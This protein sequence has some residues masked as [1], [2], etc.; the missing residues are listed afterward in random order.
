MQVL[1]AGFTVSV[2]YSGKLKDIANSFAKSRL[3]EV[4]AS[5]TSWL[6]KRNKL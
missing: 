4:G 1:I 5:D 2:L 3:G 6:I